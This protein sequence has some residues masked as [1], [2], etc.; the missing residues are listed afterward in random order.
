MAEQLNNTVQLGCGTLIIIAL[1]V[2]MFSGGD[3]RL[4]QSRKIDELS[5]KIDQLD[6]KVTQLS[7]KLDRPQSTPTVPAEKQ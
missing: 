2:A 5:S 1:I 4:R 6:A 7:S 3:D